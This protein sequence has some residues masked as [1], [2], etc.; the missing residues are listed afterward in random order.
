M[1][2]AFLRAF[3]TPDLRRKLLF[4][5]FIIAVFRLGSTL[6]TPG[7]SVKAVNRCI[8]AA[9]TSGG[10]ANV[11]QL[12]NLFSGGALLRLTV[13]ALGI[14]PYITAS[15]I[16]QLLAVV[17]PRLETLQDEGQ[18]GT[19]KITQ[20]TRYLTDRAGHPA[21]HRHRRAGQVGQAVH[22]LQRVA[23]GERRRVHRSS[24]W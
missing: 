23:A 18:A 10:S 4:T 21:V 14:M 13:F 6:P 24:R 8:N 1:L 5:L 7:I 9:T 2:T 22:R 17:I 12:V 19:A 20:Y 11:Y 3:R 16:M 15:I